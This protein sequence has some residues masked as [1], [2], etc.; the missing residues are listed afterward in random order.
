VHPQ[1]RWP[2]VQFV[3]G[4]IETVFASGLFQSSCCGCRSLRF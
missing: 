3:S 1:C 4:R 2:V